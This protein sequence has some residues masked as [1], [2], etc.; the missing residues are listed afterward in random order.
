MMGRIAALAC[1]G[2]SLAACATAQPIPHDGAAP[3]SVCNSAGLDQFVGRPATAELGAEMLRMS[4][5][6]IFR[7]LQPGQII[8]M[9]FS[10][11]RLSVH[12][13]RNGR[14]ESASCG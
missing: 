7:W 9:E 6:R 1:S 2:L 13:D 8:T 4:G 10:A 5:A 3:G 14:V 12:L 11:Q